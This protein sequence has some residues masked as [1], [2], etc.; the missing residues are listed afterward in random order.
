M[1][2][3]S[4]LPI[5]KITQEGE[6]HEVSLFNIAQINF[7]PMTATQVSKETQT[8]P[9]LSKILQYVKQGWPTTVP[10]NLKPYKTKSNELT[11]QGNC[12]L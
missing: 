5:P 10:E 4:R 9:C 12:L 3:L 2:G 11:V 1:D 7:L 6:T 8:D